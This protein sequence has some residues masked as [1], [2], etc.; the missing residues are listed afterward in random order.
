VF[1]WRKLGHIYNPYNDENR[2]AWRWNYAQGVN[3]VIFGEVVRVYFC[4]REK[5][6][7]TGQTISRVGYVDL[8]KDDLSKIIKVSDRPV[9]DDGGLGCFDEFGTYPFTAVRL[10]DKIYG[11]YG[12]VTRCES[13]P[14]NVAIG[15]AISNDGGETFVK[16]GKGPVLSY[17]QDEPFV[18]CSPKVRIFDGT[19]YMFYSAGR[20]WMQGVNRP[21]IYYKLRM[22][23]SNDG[24]NWNKQLKDII[25]DKIDVSE[26]QACGDVTFSNSRYHMFFCYRANQ[27]FRRNRAH[28]YR[29]GYAYSYDLTTWVRNDEL[30]AIDVSPKEQDFDSEMVTYPHVFEVCGKTYMLYLG[31]EVGKYGFGLAILEGNL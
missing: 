30:A 27:D 3:T 2:P 16:M 10:D 25:A 9:M 31:N 29:I 21:E 7:E 23:T 15:G 8:D 11:Y 19:W 22:A 18:V 12:G 6:N 26:A 17:S 28:S 14:F 20:E 5:P 4:C 24:V 1:T 13:V